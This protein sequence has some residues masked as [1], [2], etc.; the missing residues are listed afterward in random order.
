VLLA[1]LAATSAEVAS[2]SSRLRKVELIAAVFCDAAPEEVLA[3]VAYL[4]GELRQRR[5]GVGWASLRDLPASADTATLTVRD[6][7]E[8]FEAIAEV[9]GSGSVATRKRL[10]EELFGSATA[11]EQTF[12]AGLVRG[13]LRQGAL[14]SLVV[15][16]LA[17]AGGLPPADVRRAV[18]LRG[19]PGPVA[20]AVLAAEDGT[21]ALQQFRLEVGRPIQPM[22]AQSAGSVA[23][24]LERTGRAAVEWKLD[25]IRVQVHRD[26]DDIR[27]FTRTLDDVTDRVPEIVE[28]A[29]ALPVRSAVLDGEAIALRPDGRPKPFQ[30]TGS[31]VGSKVDIERARLETPLT[32][33]A[34]DALHLDGQ[35]LLGLGGEARHEALAAVAPQS[36]LVP[37]LV[38]DDGESAG[39]FLDHALAHGHEGVVV[40]A[41]DALYDAGR[42]GASWVKVKPVHTLDLVV[43]AV[44][45]GS[46]RRK[47]WLSN[48]HLGARDPDGGFV[49]LGKTFKGLTDE[50]LRWQTDRLL[51]LAVDRG[52]WVVTVRPE[53]VVEIAFDGVQTSSRYPGG[54]ALR[55]A[56]VVRHRPDKPASEAD[57]VDDVRALHV[58]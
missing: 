40:K 48:L 51:S 49:M 31:R 45:W 32:L 20:A 1:E 38:T 46:G 33:Y 10:L 30:V 42:R 53:L 34:F 2:T 8:A 55:F 4:G 58:Q 29:R 50:M 16:A 36:L 15:D 25:G 23:E 9:S 11:Q 47:G 21:V 12:L 22:L 26:G 6:V 13:E 3:T 39:A 14:E 35:D 52:D 5:T 17:K 54:M 44:E 19:G 57:T 37:R 28:A 41:V 43:L 7:D 24:A 18:M 27:V 56:R